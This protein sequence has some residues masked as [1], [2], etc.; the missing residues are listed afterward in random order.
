MWL[1]YIII[2]NRHTE[3]FYYF[4]NSVIR[5]RKVN[6]MN[7]EAILTVKDLS[8]TFS[9]ESVQQHVLK[10]LSL[11]IYKGD[12]TVVMGNSGSGKSTL[13]Y[14]LSGMDRP[15]LG[16]ITY[17]VDEENR[18]LRSKSGDGIEISKFSNDK[19]ALFRRYH[20]GFVFQQNYL[21][22]SMSALDNVMEYSTGAPEEFAH[23][24]DEAIQKY[25]QFLPKFKA[26]L[27]EVTQKLANGSFGSGVKVQADFYVYAVRGQGQGR[28][29]KSEHVNYVYP[30][31]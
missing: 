31:N 30:V 17:Y 27:N 23:S 25:N 5:E 6:R 18:K 26:Y 24:D 10:N 28:D 9:N 21:N 1:L 3:V 11:S 29:L 12:F 4:E 19:L 13:L 2:N 16:T 7:K 8:K 14:A 22:D 15:T 20:A